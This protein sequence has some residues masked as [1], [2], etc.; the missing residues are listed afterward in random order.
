MRITCRIFGALLAQVALVIL[1]A[2]GFA[3]DPG[4]SQPVTS[5]VSDQKAGSALVYNAYTSD[6]TANIRANTA[7]AITNTAGFSCISVHLFFIDGSTCSVADSILTLTPNQT[8]RFL[9]SDVD[10]GVTGYIVAVAID[11]AAGC[12]VNFNF[13]IGDEYIK[14]ASGHVANLGAEAFAA[15][16]TPS[17]TCNELSSIAELSFDGFHYNRAPRVLALDNIGSRANG[18][19]TL[20]IINRIGGNL[21]TGAAT[22][23]SLFGVFYDDAEKALSFSINSSACQFRSSISNNFPRIV[24]RFDQFIP[25]GRTGWM[26]ISSTTDAGILGAAINLNPNAGTDANAFNYGHNLH[27]STLAEATNYII[28]VIN[29]PNGCTL[30]AFPSK[31]IVETDAI[32]G[33]KP[34]FCVGGTI[35]FKVT[36]TGDL[37][38][39]DVE[40]ILVN[41]PGI[42]FIHRIGQVLGPG[43]SQVYESKC[44]DTCSRT[45]IVN[46]HGSQIVDM[47]VKCPGS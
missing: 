33:G 5:E 6:A 17:P 23:G 4:I 22:L 24:P 11:P 27:A 42:I 8:A 3:A 15:I 41:D 26:K 32:I 45:I 40:I 38:A 19:D 39:T 18:N 43:E 37:T 16:T 7:I 9:A 34:T 13:L 31:L 28:P 10:P 30:T 25:A 14:F 12:P 46:E 36:N 47:N 1:S 20:L 29:D 21:A 2:P 44:G 35:R